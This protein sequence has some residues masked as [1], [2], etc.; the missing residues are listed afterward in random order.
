M[1]I[2]IIEITLEIKIFHTMNYS[3]G[4]V[5]MSGKNKWNLMKH[6]LHQRQ[7]AKFMFNLW[8]FLDGTC[9]H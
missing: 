9:F 2:Y 7:K 5:Y 8:Y 6:Q 1:Y 4:L 3:L